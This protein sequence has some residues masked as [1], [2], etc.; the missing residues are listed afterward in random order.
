MIEI[1]KI[2]IK[3]ERNK[4]IEAENAGNEV[5]SG[6]KKGEKTE[7]DLKKQLERLELIVQKSELILA[8]YNSEDKECEKIGTVFVSFEKVETVY[9]VID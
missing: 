6:L 4:R 7:A 8:K 2:K 3:I 1:N 9:T 5:L